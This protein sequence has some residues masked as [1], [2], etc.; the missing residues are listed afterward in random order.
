MPLAL[1]LEPAIISRVE[2]GKLRSFVEDLTRVG[3]PGPGVPLEFQN[4]AGCCSAH[5]LLEAL[6]YDFTCLIYY[7]ANNFTR[8]QNLADE[9]HRLPS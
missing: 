7:A 1:E 2:A 5:Q 8:G 3:N 4:F 6:L 9:T